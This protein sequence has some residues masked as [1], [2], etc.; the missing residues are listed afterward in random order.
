MIYINE[1][2]KIIILVG[3]TYKKNNEIIRRSQFFGEIVSADKENGITVLINNS[4]ELFTL[5]PDLSAIKKAGKGLYTLHE[6][7]ETVINPDYIATWIIYY[8][9]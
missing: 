9:D 1:L 7:K 2:I 4:D 8:D 3:L 6:T 5:S